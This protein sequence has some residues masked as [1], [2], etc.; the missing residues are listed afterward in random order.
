MDW[1]AQ[2]LWAFHGH[3]RDKNQALNKE[4]NP[5]MH[6]LKPALLLLC[7][8]ALV[9]Q[10][11][12]EP[13]AKPRPYTMLYVF[14]DS[15]SDSGAGYVDA[16]GPTAVVYLARHLGIPFTYA[17]NPGSAGKGL[18]FAVSGASTGEGAGRSLPS[19]GTLGFGMKNQIESFVRY[20][21]GGTIP[22]IDAA[23][24][25]FFFAGGLNDGRRPDDFVRTNIESEI[26]TL[27][28]LGARRFMV[29][30]LPTRIPQ[31][32]AAGRR[33]NPELEKIPGEERVKH[34]D[35]RIANSQWGSFFDE[36]ITNPSKFGLTDTAT[37]CSD[38]PFGAQ[39]IATCTNPEAHFFY[40]EGHPSTAA[41][42]AVGELLYR[43][44]ITTAP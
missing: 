3:W 15:Y 17:G 42:R 8:G 10:Q 31:F 14:G 22:K 13:A 34:P 36:V 40:H 11:A 25:M 29:A 21:K 4:I 5:H 43:E 44:A 37:P 30:I 1:G 33:V 38:R 26:D 9:A 39:K 27:Y 23:N 2:K 35:M 19:G 7:A 16:D 6:R 28:D 12:P 24:T 32:A 18:N 41:H 20:L